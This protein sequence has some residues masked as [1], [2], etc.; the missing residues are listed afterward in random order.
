MNIKS[1]VGHRQ[2]MTILCLFI[3]KWWVDHVHK[4]CVKCWLIVTN[5]TL[6]NLV[7][8]GMMSVNCLPCVLISLIIATNNKNDD[9]KQYEMKSVVNSL[10]I[11]VDQ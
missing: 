5:M 6:D 9:A 1:N 2:V 3:Y 8:S 10:V 11:F 7:N 4:V